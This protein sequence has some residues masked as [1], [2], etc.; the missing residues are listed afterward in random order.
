[1]SFEQQ[2]DVAGCGEKNLGQ[3]LGPLL[4]L[5]LPLASCGTLPKSLHLSVSQFPNL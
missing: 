5:V 2:S 1:M 3:K 4:V